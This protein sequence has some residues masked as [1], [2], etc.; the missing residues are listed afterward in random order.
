MDSW[1]VAVLGDGGVG[2]T[3]LAVQVS[4]NRDSSVASWLMHTT[5]HPQLFRR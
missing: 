3:A 4:D 5:V 2:K 1:R